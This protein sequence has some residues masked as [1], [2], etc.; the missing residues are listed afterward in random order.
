ML[1]FQLDML[2]KHDKIRE[3]REYAERALHAEV[4]EAF[5]KYYDAS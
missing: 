2:V 3:I 4:I 5:G 1:G